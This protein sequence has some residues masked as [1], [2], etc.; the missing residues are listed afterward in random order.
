MQR[1]GIS[2][3][4]VIVFVVT[5]PL[6]AQVFPPATDWGP[7][8]QHR[9]APGISF[10]VRCDGY[11]DLAKQYAWQYEFRNNYDRA[12]DLEFKIEGTAL[13][14]TGLRPKQSATAGRILKPNRCGLDSLTISIVAV[15]DSASGER[16]DRAEAAGEATTGRAESAPP[17]SGPNSIA[18]TTWACT[19]KGGSHRFRFLAD[20]QVTDAYV[21]GQWPSGLD[22]SE[23]LGDRWQQR[24]QVVRWGGSIVMEGVVEPGGLRIVRYADYKGRVT[25]AINWFEEKLTFQQM[26]AGIGWEQPCRPLK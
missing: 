9:G 4:S 25:S 24:G 12:V 26:P 19:L 3:A 14:H 10:R 11:N 5:A 22:L 18:G 21:P 20:G 2:L 8:E 23:P 1:R 15:V 13:R 17:K 16:I 6:A 7:W